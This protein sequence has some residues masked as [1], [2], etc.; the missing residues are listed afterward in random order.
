MT[1]NW[2]TF[3]FGVAIALVLATSVAA[4]ARRPT[5]PAPKPGEMV[6]TLIRLLQDPDFTVR[7]GAARGL[8]RIGAP[9]RRAVPLL[10]E[11]LRDAHVE[12][13]EAAE[14][15]LSRIAETAREAFPELTCVAMIVADGRAR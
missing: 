9:A 10:I 5:P 1:K 6:D 12:V 13:R 7:R 8:G 2:A 11:A 3:L 4:G 15:A 14:R